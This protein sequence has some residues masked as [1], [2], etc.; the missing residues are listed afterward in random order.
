MNKRVLIVEDEFIVANDI[1]CFLKK[2]NY[3][4]IGV[5][6]SVDEAIV[7]IEKERPYLVL[8]DIHLKTKLTGIDLAKILQLRSIPFIYLSAYSNKSILHEAQLTKPYGFLVK[9]FREKD[10]RVS[11]EIA[12][13]HLLHSENYN[14]QL[15][16]SLQQNLENITVSKDW[17]QI[18]G[19]L[20]NVFQSNIPYN[21]FHIALKNDDQ[22]F[23]LGFN[24]I[25]LKDYQ[26]IGVPE[27]S[28][29]SKID[30]ETIQKTVNERK[31]GITSGVYDGQL[32]E[33]VVQKCAFENLISKFF[34]VESAMFIS[35]SF[36]YN[37]KLELA[38]YNRK[39]QVYK[40]SHLDV[41]KKTQKEIERLVL[42]LLQVEFTSKDQS[43]ELVKT[44]VNAAAFDRIIGNSAE[45][46]S[47][48]DNI[49]R[50]A[51]MPSSVLILGESG[52][53]KELFAR[54][55]HDLSLRS[56]KPYVV[57]NCGAIPENLIE[58]TLFG[59]EKGSFTGATEMRIG[60]FEQANGGTIFL[61]EIGEMPL[62]MQ[63]KLLRVLQEMEIERIGGTK[64]IPIDV[65][66][67]AATNRNLEEQVEAGKFR[68]DLYY[69]LHVF[70]IYTPALRKR[71]ED[72]PLLVSYF[73]NKICKEKIE[74]TKQVLNKMMDYHWPGNIRELENYIER[75]VLLA[76]NSCIDQFQIS[77]NNSAVDSHKTTTAILKPLFTMERD[78]ILSV[79]RIC[80]GK[81]Y[82]EGGAAE[83]LQIPSS[84]LNSKIKKLGIS[85][86]EIYS[87]GIN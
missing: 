23:T 85:K 25:G 57:I 38:F 65:R 33:E 17:K 69:R 45:L 2:E 62:D 10:L 79:L 73:I 31:F 7:Y 35:L 30:T 53:G 14:S 58:S 54:S 24:R 39:S 56:K 74:V 52:T 77:N 4:V 28:T 11:L 22:E 63:V 15:E 37:I 18:F 49:R 43:K 6:S 34:N 70:P 66:V 47:V 50:V 12:A 8:L 40:S 20:A 83:I 60:K 59:H 64:T 32:F 44:T 1:A 27:L 29:I 71:K 26:I 9:P 82:G 48:F 87:S 84:T 46:L 81:V 42:P 5:A 68:L 78:Y 61:D 80:K 41:F 21:Y 16:Q 55:I 72:I 67:I 86:E 13:Y 51:P 3:D 36:P 19:E 75:S 76:K